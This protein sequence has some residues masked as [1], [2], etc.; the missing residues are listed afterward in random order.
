MIK[1]RIKGEHEKESII[2]EISVPM[3]HSDDN[4]NVA[5]ADKP[6]KPVSGE[7]CSTTKGGL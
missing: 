7:A 5:L 3:H 6:T 2:H 4:K 1:C